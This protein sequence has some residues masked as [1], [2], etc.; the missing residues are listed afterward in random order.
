MK[1]RD[2]MDYFSIKLDMTQGNVGASLAD[3]LFLDALFLDALFL[4]ACCL[5]DTP[6]ANNTLLFLYNV[7]PTRYHNM[8]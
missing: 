7:K 2:C 1:V 8:S 5:P 6:L 4:Q 3:A